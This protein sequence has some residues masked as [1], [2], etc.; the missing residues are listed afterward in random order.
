MWTKK[1]NAQ[2]FC[3][4]SAKVPALSTH[5][6]LLFMNLPLSLFCLNSVTWIFCSNYFA[7][8]KC[9]LLV[10]SFYYYLVWKINKYY[11]KNMGSVGKIW[12]ENFDICQLLI[13]VKIRL[14]KIPTMM[15]AIN[16]FGNPGGIAPSKLHF[17]VDSKWS[18]FAART[19][20]TFA[21]PGKEHFILVIL[22]QFKKRTGSF[23][24]II[25]KGK[26]WI[27][28]PFLG[29]QNFPFNF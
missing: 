3:S 21:F 14:W 7:A 25:G 8:G 1:K 9:P 5:A 19:I 15:T 18:R 12:L 16:A 26:V 10:Q 2:H 4:F 24:E 20:R 11:G 13:V 22:F 17:A 29:R 23:R 6:F 28:L 27:N